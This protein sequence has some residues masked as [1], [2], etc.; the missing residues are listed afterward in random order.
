[1]SWII[2]WIKELFSNNKQNTELYVKDFEKNYGESDQL[3]VGLYSNQNPLINKNIIIKINDR[4]YERKTDENGIARLNINLL[5]GK[6]ETLFT[7]NGD[8]EYNKSTAH[9][10]VYVNPIISTNDLSMHYK[11]GSKFTATLTDSKNNKL[12]NVDLKFNVN[13]VDYIRKT[14]EYGVASLNINLKSGEYL[15]KTIFNNINIVNHIFITEK[16][17][18]NNHFGYWIFGKDMLNVDIDKLRDNG[19]TDIFL[20]YY[21]FTTHGEQKVK[22]FISNAKDINVHI[23]MQCFYDGEWHNPVNTDLSN[24]IEEASKYA[25]IDGVDGVHLDYLR[26]PGNAYKTD[27]GVEAITNF[28]SKVR[29]A[30]PKNIILSC[31]VMPENE[32]KYYYGQDIDALGK[33]V[34]VIIPMQ[35]KGN[36]NANTSWLASTTKKFST[37]TNIWS[38]LQSYKSDNDTSLLSVDELSNDIK[39]CLDNGANGTILFR[40]GLSNDINFK[41]YIKNNNLKSTRMEGTDINMTYKDGTKYQC[42]VYDNDNNRVKDSVDITVNG[43]TYNKKSDD[44]GLYKLNINLNP[45]TY[46]IKAEF[47]GNEKYS[48]SYVNNTIRIN[49]KTVEENVDTTVNGCTNPYES[50]PHPTN[51][52]CNGMGQNTSTY[53]APSSVHKILYKFGIR[54][55]SQSQLASWMGT[56]SAGTS[57]DGIATGIAKVNQVKGTNINIKWYN[58]SDLT[59]EKIGKLICQ[60]NIG[61]LCHILYKN[62]GTCSGS[63]NFGHYETLVKV[64]TATEYVKVINSLGNYCGSCYCGYYQ[65]R[66]MACQKQFIMGISQK[67]IAVITKQ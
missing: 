28:V 20:N 34:D 40:Y 62:G 66:S 30:I 29:E 2:D 6:Y 44:E 22:E 15:I 16:N 17:E 53:C 67:S 65:D 60:P 31:A 14:N 12:S 59:W 32:T 26:Y 55:I 18:N 58:L 38:G 1:M 33:I 45:G 41:Q 64:N 24:R 49:E 11:D 63:G 35:Y 39:T 56:N 19:V 8:E 52:G 37:L 46:P 21:A 51:T 9:C 27:G 25:N 5:V 23:W 50:S 61:I 48:P 3:E 42:A 13:G 7:F 47:K 57:H 10:K 43:V 36:Y 4:E 54:D